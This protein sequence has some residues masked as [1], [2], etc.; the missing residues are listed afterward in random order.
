MLTAVHPYDL[1][2]PCP[3][4]QHCGHVNATVAYF[5]REI[6]DPN[7]VLAARARASLDSLVETL[8]T[9]EMIG[10]LKQVGVP[11]PWRFTAEAR[12][13]ARRSRSARVAA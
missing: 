1:P 4:W 12:A 7:P 8:D 3:D 6:H 10:L 5:Q 13:Q 2:Q 9:H 11:N